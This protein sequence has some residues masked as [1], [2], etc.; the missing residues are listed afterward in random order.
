ARTA[1]TRCAR[2]ADSASST[3]PNFV[4]P[5]HSGL[6]CADRVN[7]SAMPGIRVLAQFTSV[8]T[9]MA[10]TK[11]GH[12][13]YVVVAAATDTRQNLSQNL[14]IERHGRLVFRIMQHQRCSDV[15]HMRRRRQIGD[16]VL[17]RRHIAGHAFQDKVDLSR[18]HPA[19]PYQRLGAHEFL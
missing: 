11:P 18:Q 5:G 2:R 6:P 7:L 12:D 13:E 17:K 14:H 3:T 10:G 4:M 16:E 9:W 8:K 15:A 19:L 1:S